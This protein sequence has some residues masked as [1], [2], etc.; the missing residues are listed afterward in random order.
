MSKISVII[1][2][3]NKE[4]SIIECLTSIINQRY[5]PYEL[6]IVNDGSTDNSKDIVEAFISND[7]FKSFS[8]N[9]KFLTI[10]NSGVSVARNYG[11]S[12][13]SKKSEYICFIDADDCWEKNYLCS[14]IDLATK[15][16]N[17]DFFSCAHRK[18]YFHNDLIK[19]TKDFKINSP[20]KI[21]LIDNYYKYSNKT[22]IVNS[23]KLFFRYSSVTSQLFPEGVSM[24]EDHYAWHSLFERGN[25]SIIYLN[26]ILV[27]IN[28]MEDVSRSARNFSIPYLIEYYSKNTFE[29]KRQ[30]IYFKNFLFKIFIK[31]FIDSLIKSNYNHRIIVSSSKIFGWWIYCFCTL[32][33]IPTFILVFFVNRFKK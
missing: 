25:S 23:S 31:H 2:L 24:G 11:L 3:Y 7:V 17:V 16:N 19:S 8:I 30:S 22:S 33:Y 32:K 15:Y 21:F 9:V 4:Y 14:M 26:Q 29:F 28:V 13:V 27:N 18:N 10:E 20:Q 5:I 6:I 1:P 12:N